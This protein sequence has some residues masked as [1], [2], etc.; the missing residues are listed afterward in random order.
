[1]KGGYFYEGRLAD[2]PFGWGVANKRGGFP[3]VGF[4]GEDLETVSSIYA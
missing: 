2:Q 1:L 4:V 3:E